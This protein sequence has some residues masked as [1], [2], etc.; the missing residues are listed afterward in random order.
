MDQSGDS[1]LSIEAAIVATRYL[2]HKPNE[3]LGVEAVCDVVDL[4]G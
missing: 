2:F 1:D 4:L 3:F